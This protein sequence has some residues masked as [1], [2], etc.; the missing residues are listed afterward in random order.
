MGNEQ[1]WGVQQGWPS[2]CTT[3]TL[4]GA[5]ARI[6]GTYMAI[7][8]KLG[9]NMKNAWWRCVE[10]LGILCVGCASYSSMEAAKR[11]ESVTL[12]V[13]PRSAVRVNLGFASQG[14][15]QPRPGWGRRLCFQRTTLEG[16]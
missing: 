6:T 11:C 13:G 14:K 2:V 15:Q 8:S 3:Q 9:L 10:M 1:C 12:F 16:W 7:A 4:V 5:L